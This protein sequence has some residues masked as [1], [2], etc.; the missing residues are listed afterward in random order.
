MQLHMSQVCVNGYRCNSGDMFSGVIVK[1]MMKF[2]RHI[3]A[4]LGLKELIAVLK[5][6][7]GYGPV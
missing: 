3:Y 4:S 6:Q 5:V 7:H 1:T 2:Y